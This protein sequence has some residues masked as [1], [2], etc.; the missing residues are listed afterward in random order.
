[1]T[2]ENAWQEI[3][4]FLDVMYDDQWPHFANDEGRHNIDPKYWPTTV[5]PSELQDRAATID[6]CMEMLL[7]EKS[8]VARVMIAQWVAAE[9]GGPCDLLTELALR[10]YK[11][12][13]D[14]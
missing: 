11:P 2:Q 6:V 5:P 12:N 14:Y 8:I 7:Q 13:I 10:G 9:L 3:A 1:M 4:G